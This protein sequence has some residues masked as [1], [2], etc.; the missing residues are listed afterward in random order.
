MKLNQIVAL[1]KGK[2]TRVKQ[3]LTDLHHGWKSEKLI[4]MT[5]VYHPLI[6]AVSAL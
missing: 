1:I 5:R 4:G 6:I 3:A 2:K